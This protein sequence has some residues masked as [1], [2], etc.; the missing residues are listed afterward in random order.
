MRILLVSDLHYALPQFDWVVQ[1]ASDVDLVVFAGDQLNI[2][3]SVALSTQSV[4]V[5]NYVELIAASTSVVVSSGNH[6]LT[7]LD[8]HGENAALWISGL[9]DV[10]AVV[11][12]DS[13]VVDDHLVSVFPWW[14]GPVGRD[15]VAAQMAADAARRPAR[16]I[17]VYHWPPVDSPTS[18]IGSRHYGDPDL[19]AWIAEHQPDMVFTGHV[20]NPPFKPAGSWFD[21]I[22]PTWVFNPG[23]QIGPTPT[24]IEIDLGEMAA[25]WASQ[26]GVERIDLSVEG[27]P[28]RPL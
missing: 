13:I 16:W 10:G 2:A 6:D 7:G 4:V 11:D 12:S 17:W 5:R 22:G 21:R 3:S 20:H 25:V 1:A 23:N 19:A 26:M 24:M 15:R 9:R 27:R 18:W 14:D 8:E 28:V